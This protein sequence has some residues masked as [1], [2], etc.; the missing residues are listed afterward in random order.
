MHRRPPTILLTVPQVAL[1]LSL[2]PQTVYALLR[3]RRLP[4][5]K[6]GGQWRIVKARLDAWLSAGTCRHG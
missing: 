5:R 3:Q 6:V 1:Y 4:A 2:H